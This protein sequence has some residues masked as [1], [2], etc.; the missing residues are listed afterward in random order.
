MEVL[1][2]LIIPI[3]VGVLINLISKYLC[4]WIDRNQE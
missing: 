1:T 2:A 3:I 4:R